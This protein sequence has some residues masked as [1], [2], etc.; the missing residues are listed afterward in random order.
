MFSSLKSVLPRHLREFSRLI[1]NHRVEQTDEGLWILDANALALGTYEVSCNGGPWV[2]HKNIL[3]LEGMNHALDVLLHGVA[4]TA[5]WYVAPF[6]GNVTP[7]LTHTAAN[8]ASSFTEL[9]T[10][11]SESTR[12]AYVEGAAAGG[13]TNNYSSP[14]TITTAVDTVTVYGAG[15]LSVSTKGSTSGILLS[16]S[17]YTAPY[18]LPTTGGTLGIKYQ[19]SLTSS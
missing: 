5:T 15:L 18:S 3:T 2:A 6:S 8:F 9:T 13:V 7:L 10:Q 16:V 14:A 11:Y 19:V 17:K 12:V 1:R 4:A